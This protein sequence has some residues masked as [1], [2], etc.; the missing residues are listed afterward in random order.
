MRDPG[1]APRWLLI[2]LGTLGAVGI[3]DV[4]LAVLSITNW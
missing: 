1:S 3:A 4:T 2:V